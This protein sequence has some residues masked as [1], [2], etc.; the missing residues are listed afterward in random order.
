V[1]V[2][3]GATASGKTELALELALTV[4][5]ELVS[6]DSVQVYRGFD[7]GSAKLRG[8]AARGVRQH[9]VDVCEPDEPLDAKAYA[10]LA[11]AAIAD[12]ASRGAL[13]IVVGGTGLWVRALL[14]GLIPAPPVDPALRRRLLDEVERLGAPAMH[15]ALEAVD[16][17][18]A[19]RI[20]PNDA[21]RIVRALEVFEQTG[22]PVGE[23]RAAHARGSPRYDAAYVVLER[24]PDE[25]AV[26]IAART[27]A[28][29]R[30]GL[31]EEVRGLRDRYGDRARA[32][33][34]VGY[35]EVVAMLEG[36][37]SAE[38]LEMAIVRATRAYARR[39]RVW[40][41]TDPDVTHRAN[42]DEVAAVL[43]S[44]S[45]GGARDADLPSRRRAVIDW[46][47]GL[48]VQGDP[49]DV[50]WTRQRSVPV[51]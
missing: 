5:G 42:A 47:R 50:T 1:L 12:I 30:D 15:R 3:G 29:L 41:A 33:G 36:K 37:N 40:L 28:M 39:Q 14:R 20:H 19:A 26:R 7:I 8:K 25:L 23:L 34:A 45:V 17:R 21:V 46:A 11:E 18:A 10:T 48:G 44:L 24:P 16:P 32:L 35:R 22:R 4:G 43:R 38:N 6:A 27:R 9:L 51:P 2:I 31:V 13:P 49:G